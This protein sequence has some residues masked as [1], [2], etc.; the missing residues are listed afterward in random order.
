MSLFDNN[1]YQWRETYFVYFRRADRPKLPVVLR[2]LKDSKQRLRL[3]NERADEEDR[4][5]SITIIAADSNSAMDIA[6][7]EGEEVADAC[8]TL[9]GEMS[10][11]LGGMDEPEKLA[12]LNGCDMRMEVMHFEEMVDFPDLDEDEMEDMLEPTALLGVLG[13]LAAASNGVAIDP[14]SG[15]FP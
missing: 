12:K 13:A 4:F 5:E 7:V 2:C 8:E 15:T 9:I 3:E 14:Q 1:N 11:E 10:G 6:C